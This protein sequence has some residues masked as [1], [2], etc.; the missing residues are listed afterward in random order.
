MF[1][2]AKIWAF[3]EPQNMFHSLVP[4]EILKEYCDH[5][6]IKEFIIPDIMTYDHPRRERSGRVILQRR[7]FE[8]KTMRVDSRMN[9]GRSQQLKITPF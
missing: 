3:C 1:K 7:I 5:H 6:S 9:K 4:A 2:K 8:E